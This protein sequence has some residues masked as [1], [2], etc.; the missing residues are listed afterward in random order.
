MIFYRLLKAIVKPFRKKR[1]TKFSKVI[2]PQPTERILDVGGTLFN[3]KLIGFENDVVLLNTSVSK[4]TNEELPSNFSSV[5]G[6][7]TALQYE[8]K[9]FDVCF[10]NSV[11]EHVGTLEKQKMF[12]KEVCRVGKRV[13]IYTPAKSFFFE[14]HYFTLFI[15]WLP[16]HYQKKLIR[17][18]SV[19]GLLTRPTQQWI[20]YYVNQTRLLTFK[21]IKALFPG[22]TIKRERFLFMTKGYVIVKT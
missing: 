16:K 21:E 17:Y 13:W 8:D 18:F 1:M 7:G 12:A 20:D 2:D 19:L 15:H 14:P 10:S 6:D 4:N 5:V 3:W 9:E 22:C 11:I